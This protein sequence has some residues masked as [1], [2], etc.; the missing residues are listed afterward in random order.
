MS[1]KIDA[2]SI[3][4]QRALRQRRLTDAALSLALEGGAESI[5][6]SAVAA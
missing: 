6:V 4:D 1:P 3:A 5:T 2:D